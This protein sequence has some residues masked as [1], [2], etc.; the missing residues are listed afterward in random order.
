V[1]L[2]HVSRD[3]ISVPEGEKTPS[4]Y[5]G[6]TLGSPEDPDIGKVTLQSITLSAVIYFQLV[7]DL[8]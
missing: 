3:S 1:K 5:I 6:R 7:I 2:Q 8:I 4:L